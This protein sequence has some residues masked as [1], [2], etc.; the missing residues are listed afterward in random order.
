MMAAPHTERNRLP[1]V[2]TASAAATSR[3]RYASEAITT[4]AALAARKNRLPSCSSMGSA[5][6]GAMASRASSGRTSRP[7][8]VAIWLQRLRYS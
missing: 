4:T 7:V 8:A 6:M 3:P 2:R 5:D 1:T